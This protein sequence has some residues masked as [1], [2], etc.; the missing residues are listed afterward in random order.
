MPQE[1]PLFR[2]PEGHRQK[3]RDTVDSLFLHDIRRLSIG[4]LQS[5]TPCPYRVGNDLYHVLPPEP[6]LRLFGDESEPVPVA[7]TCDCPRALQLVQEV[8][9]NFPRCS[10]NHCPVRVVRELPD[11]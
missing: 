7:L 8:A 9:P 2:E 11:E 1:T 3:F 10:K 6:Q 4:R 5:S